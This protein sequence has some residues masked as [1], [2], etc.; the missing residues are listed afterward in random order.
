M[1]AETLRRAIS[2]KSARCSKENTWPVDPTARSSQQLNAPDPA[3]ASSTFA[4]GNTS[5]IVTICAA[6]FG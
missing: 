5:P 6:S 4:P 2:A 1:K 3:P